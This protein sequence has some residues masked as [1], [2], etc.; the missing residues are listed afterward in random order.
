MSFLLPRQFSRRTLRGRARA[1]H[2]FFHASKKASKPRARCSLNVGRRSMSR[3]YC[4]ATLAVPVLIETQSRQ[5]WQMGAGMQ[6]SL[7][8]AEAANARSNRPGQ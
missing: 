5:G 1:L 3:C 2:V 7:G 6:A 4:T 8:G